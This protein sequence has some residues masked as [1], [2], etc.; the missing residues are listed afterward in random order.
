[1]ARFV[2]L[3]H[4]FCELVGCSQTVRRE[5][6]VLLGTG[7]CN[8]VL[9]SAPLSRLLLTLLGERR[10][11]VSRHVVLEVQIALVRGTLVPAEVDTEV[12]RLDVA[13]VL[14]AQW[15]TLLNRRRRRRKREVS[16]GCTLLSFIVCC[17][18]LGA[19]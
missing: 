6:S 16:L 5:P 14:G 9:A 10:A 3:A 2:Q 18:S 15:L 12:R 11:A 19:D 4:L 17:W 13:S 8:G 7:E 1:M